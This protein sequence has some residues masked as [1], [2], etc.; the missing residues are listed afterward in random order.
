[1]SDFG[2]DSQFLFNS[3]LE[4]SRSSSSSTKNTHI[5]E[6]WRMSPKIINL[7]HALCKSNSA[8]SLRDKCIGKSLPNSG[9]KTELA[10]RLLLSLEI[11]SEIT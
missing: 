10:H 3:G 2:S 9:T 8:E 6:S 4:V 5:P 7:T 11:Q 1:L